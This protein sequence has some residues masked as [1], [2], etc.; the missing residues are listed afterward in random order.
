MPTKPETKSETQ[1]ELT[2]SPSA[3]HRKLGGAKPKAEE[4][5]HQ[6]SDCSSASEFHVRQASTAL[7]TCE[8]E[9]NADGSQLLEMSAEGGASVNFNN[10]TSGDLAD[11]VSRLYGLVNS[12]QDENEEVL[13][14]ASACMFMVADGIRLRSWPHFSLTIV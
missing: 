3:E 5:A 10:L 11:L 8:Q 1:A 2:C 14:K 6:D 9:S 12:L 13:L 7:D 4:S